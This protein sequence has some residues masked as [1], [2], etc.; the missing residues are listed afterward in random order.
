MYIHVLNSVRVCVC[1]CVCDWPLLSEDDGEDSVGTRADS[2]HV[3][4]CHRSTHREI[5]RADKMHY[6]SKLISASPRM[7]CC[8]E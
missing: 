3:G 8:G 7:K 1:M 4:G 2:I 5:E 6:I